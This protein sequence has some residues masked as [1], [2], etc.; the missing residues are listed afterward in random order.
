MQVL[1]AQIS[2]MR[3]GGNGERASNRRDGL[4]RQSFRIQ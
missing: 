1:Q 4:V 3:R 2:R